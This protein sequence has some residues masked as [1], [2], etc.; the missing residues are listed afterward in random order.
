MNERE[1]DEA[2]AEAE[3]I[4]REAG[5]LVL[6]GYRKPVD[7]RKKGEIDLV[8]EY[9]VKSE[10]FIRAAL[11]KSFPGTSVVGEEGEQDDSA[12]HVWYVDPIDGTTNFAHG[13][14][15]WGISLALCRD[16]EPI[17]GVVF[18]PS[19]NVC[20]KARKGGGALRNETPCAVSQTKDMRQALCATGFPYDRHTTKDDNLR[21]WSAFIQRTVGIRRCGAA[22]LDLSMVADGTFEVFWEQKLK[23]WDMAAGALFVRE[24]GG[25]A[26]DYT[27]RPLDMKRG[28]VL[29]TNDALKDFAIEIMAE[30]RKGMDY[31]SDPPPD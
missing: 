24:A 4:A 17:A 23:I 1:L 14:P 13:H 20:W 29:A 15:Y 5:K 30:A 7:I 8:T 3:R 25:H 16:L 12:E 2:V 11:A 10:D 31:W 22:A 9:D 26:L 21:E 27:G 18:A 19:L 28:R 6:E